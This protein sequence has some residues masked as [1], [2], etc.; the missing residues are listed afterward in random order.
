VDDAHFINLR[1][2]DGLEVSNHFKWLANEFPVTF[3]FVGV[4][5]QERGLMSE[6]LTSVD[7]AMAQT[8]RRWTRLG[9]DAFEI[10]TEQGRHAW[11]RLLLAIEQRLVLANADRGMVAD[12]LSDYLYARSGGHIGSLMTL[13]IRGC[14]RAVRSGEER[15]TVELLDRVKND[16]AAEKVRG[17]LAGAIAA[18]LLA[19]RPGTQRGSARRA[20]AKGD[21][22]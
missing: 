17:A 4:G 7:A 1:R 21:A 6:G 8:A 5:L 12:E 11:R 10:H 15:L 18:G 20:T 16:E 22:A 3:L 13:I 14:Y 19:S 9:V 2:K